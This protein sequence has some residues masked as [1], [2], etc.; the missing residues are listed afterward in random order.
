MGRIGMDVDLVEDKGRLFK[1]V[2]KTPAGITT[3]GS[4]K[5][6]YRIDLPERN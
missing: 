2:A 3:D 1:A 4:S 5:R 6:N